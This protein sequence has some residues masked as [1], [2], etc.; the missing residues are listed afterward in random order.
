MIWL[1]V[2]VA[3]IV[4]PLIIGYVFGRNEHDF[5]ADELAGEYDDVLGI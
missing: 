1:I 2:F 5:L 3:P 4:F